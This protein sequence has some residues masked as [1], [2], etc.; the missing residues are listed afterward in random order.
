MKI[1]LIN[2]WVA[3]AAPGPF[4][5]PGTWRDTFE[6]ACALREQGQEVE[7]LTTKIRSPHVKRFQKEFGNELRQKGI[8]HHFAEA[9]LSFGRSFGGFRLRMFF[10]E[11]KVIKKSKP[12][13]V[14]Y[15]QFCPSLIYPFIKKTPVVFYSCYFFDHYL[16]GKQGHQEKVDRWQ[17]HGEFKL[18]AIFQNI[19]FTLISK[20]LGSM[21][22]ESTLRRGA[23]V[24]SMHPEGYKKL[25]EKFGPKSKIYL[26]EKGVNGVSSQVGKKGGRKKVILTFIG[27]TVNRKGVFDLLKAI[28]I[29]QQK[30]LNVK[31]LIAGSGPNA[32]VIKLKRQFSTLRQNVKYLGPV[33]FNKKWAVLRESDIFC[34]P[35][36]LDAYPS[37]ILEA[38]AEGI[39]VV[40]TKEIDSPIVDGISGLLVNAGDI[41]SLADAIEKLAS[42][43]KLRQKIGRE[44]QNVV[45]NLTWS[46]QTQT[47]VDLYQKFLPP[48]KKNCGFSTEGGSAS[49]GQAVDE[50]SNQTR[51]I[52]RLFVRLP[53][54]SLKF[55][56]LFAILSNFLLWQLLIPIWHF[57]DEQ[58][59]FGQVAFRADHGRVQRYHE[60][61]T[62]REIFVSEE[63]LGTKR[64]SI[65]NNS[66]TYHPEFKI[67][68]SKTY[69][70][71]YEAD[72]ESLN[73][74]N[75]RTAEVLE[76]STRYPLLYYYLASNVYNSFK[77]GDL[78]TR[79]YAVR[80]FSL[81]IFL[82]TVVTIFGISKLIFPKNFLLQ[83]SLTN[84]VSFLPM[85]I[86][87]S[88][89]VTSDGLF[90]FLFMVAIYLI[91]KVTFF[92]YSIK[93]ILLLVAVILA[94]IGTKFQ[95]QIIWPIIAFAVLVNF[96]GLQFRKKLI[97]MG[98]LVI[99]IPMILITINFLQFFV[100]DYGIPPFKQFLRLPT[101]PETEGSQ[102]ESMAEFPLTSYLIGAVRHTVAEVLPW[103]F[104]VYKWL[105]LTLPPI[106]Y[107][108]INRILMLS[109][110]GLLILAYKAIR[111]KQFDQQTKV[112]IFL[113]YIAIVYFLSIIIFDWF[114]IRGHG[115]SFGI[116]GRYFFPTIIAH[117]SLVF[118]GLVVLPPKSF[119]KWIAAT[120]VFITV[121]FNYFSLFWVA[122]HYYDLESLNMF[123]IQ[124]SQ[125]KP[126]I[127]KGFGIIL[128]LLLAITSLALFLY[129]YIKLVTRT[130]LINFR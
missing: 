101:I 78:F 27:T 118:V 45:Q 31:L 94:G 82:G 128:V 29:V 95:F 113:A 73:N 84:I 71:P 100:N 107:K 125:Y 60:L 109:V 17:G 9:H 51:L 41:Q 77:N 67:D 122:S 21:D 62:S 16:K 64:D 25:R 48:A 55:T 20:L 123:I 38:M 7:I 46:K 8:V 15:M 54:Y 81:A 57:P 4:Y 92:K 105:S 70:G 2:K 23:L 52:K 56:L 79:I 129:E 86:F 112:L 98:S 90:H 102:L 36:Y 6:L 69:D 130:K 104:G 68:Y 85:F 1:L 99:I 50:A 42:N 63:L 49:G 24:I 59:H 117:I 11:L 75:D 35:S 10:D 28:K 43:P 13:I 88:A 121:I 22:L 116:Q 76:E 126:E 30:N 87:S 80:L 74:R 39:P 33:S 14:Q 89:G 83:I 124:A 3:G 26:V 18:W 97:F 58:A 108:I 32:A 47:L 61:S 34:L 115:F 12:D 114:F 44:G 96:W 110:L 119:K 37:A 53:K 127:F 5:Y 19:L 91:A 65:G 111:Q 103:Y 120:L 93:D 40:S 66:F 106:V 72:I